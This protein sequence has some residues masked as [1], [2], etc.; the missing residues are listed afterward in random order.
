MS[1][2]KIQSHIGTR[3]LQHTIQYAS[4]NIISQHPGS[5]ERTCH[6]SGI[7]ASQNFSRCMAAP[8]PEPPSAVAVAVP[9]PAAATEPLRLPP[10]ETRHQPYPK[11]ATSRVGQ[12]QYWYA[13]WFF[14][15]LIQGTWGCILNTILLNPGASIAISHR[16]SGLTHTFLQNFHR[17]TGLR[18]LTACRANAKSWKMRSVGMFKN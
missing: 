7:Q 11:K 4:P 12:C 3:H 2:Q 17:I 13:I 10:A 6:K 9:S 18:V 16:Q 5:N 8:E 1:S 15:L 14:L